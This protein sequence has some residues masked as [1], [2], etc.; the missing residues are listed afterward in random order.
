MKVTIV[1]DN[2]AY[3][4][5]F[6]PEHG[7]SCYLEIK[8]TPRIL[9]DTG[10]SGTTLL[11]N[12]HELGIDPLAIDIIVLSHFHRD[13]TGGLPE[14]LQANHTARLF[15]PRSFQPLLADRELIQVD[16]AAIEVT[17]NV[18]STGELRGIEQSLVVKTDKDLVVIAGCSH[19]GVGQILEAA[20]S[21]GKVSALIGGLHGFREFGILKDL[22]L[23]C[24]CH[25]TQH[26]LEIKELYPDT[27]L[28]GG[29]GRVIEI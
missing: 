9:F 26:K 13:H 29:V 5:G 1:F 24:P 3:K 12:M 10:A 6:L 20:S 28:D 17:N 21:Y 4:N 15:V 19:P 2:T 22:Q 18:F 27:C 16:N 23:V 8:D 7:F 25:C 11:H 14:L